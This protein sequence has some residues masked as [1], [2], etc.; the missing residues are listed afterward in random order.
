MGVLGETS[1]ISVKGERLDRS[2]SYC[3][4]PSL[5][6]VMG[7]GKVSDFSTQIYRESTSEISPGFW[8]FANNSLTKNATVEES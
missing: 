6:R 3:N 5:F 2:T 7:K 1:Q 4:T 8:N